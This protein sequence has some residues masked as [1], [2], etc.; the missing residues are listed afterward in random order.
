[1][2]QL[3]HS[4]YRAPCA[5]NALFIQPLDKPQLGLLAVN[6]GGLHP[7]DL[8]QNHLH[9]HVVQRVLLRLHLRHGGAVADKGIQHLLQIDVGADILIDAQDIVQPFLTVPQE[10]RGGAQRRALAAE[11]L[12]PGGIVEAL[13][14]PLTGHQLHG[15]Q[16]ILLAYLPP[17]DVSPGDP[18]DIT[19]PVM[20]HHLRLRP[21]HMGEE[22]TEFDQK[23]LPFHGASALSR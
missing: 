18:D 8:A 16:Q 5:E 15:G 21:H 7:G 6:I 22:I 1:M 12:V 9:H 20:E 23:F 17:G 2:Q 4:A 10:Q 19:V 14:R 3:A 13:C 11:A